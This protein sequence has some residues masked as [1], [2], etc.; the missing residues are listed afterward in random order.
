MADSWGKQE[1]LNEK[2]Y[3]ALSYLPHITMVVIFVFFL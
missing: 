2:I 3:T 1:T